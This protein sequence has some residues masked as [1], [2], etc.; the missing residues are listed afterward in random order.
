MRR[1]WVEGVVATAL[2]LALV[3]P[4]RAIEASL[5]VPYARGGWVWA[6][7]KL[8][9]PIAPRVAES[10]SRGM[11]A[12][13]QLHA[14]LWRRRSGW[15]DRL[16]SSYDAA[17]RIRFEVWN[18]QFRLERSGLKEVFVPSLDSLRAVLSRPL[19]VP[20]ARLE[21]LD[22]DKRYY[23]VATATLK[24]LSVEDAEEV[25]GWLSGEVEDKARARLG[26]I[27][28]LPR[29]VFDAVRNFAGFGDQKARAI[30]TDFDGREMQAASR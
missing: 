13:L 14:E 17:V 11:P 15:F 2:T 29:A 16:E 24:P 20:V 23:V 19:A 27:T 30:S 10:L 6:D 8:D 4:A 1:C 25:E 5:G 21:K 7:V 12:T 22:A 9:D 28:A 3:T 18:D 26:I